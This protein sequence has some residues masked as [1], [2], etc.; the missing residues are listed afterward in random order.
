M[1]I[2]STKSHPNLMFRAFIH[3]DMTIM[4]YRE[5]F[6]STVRLFSFSRI[7]PETLNDA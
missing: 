6:P 3:F 1:A 5:P 4:S 2:N 7:F